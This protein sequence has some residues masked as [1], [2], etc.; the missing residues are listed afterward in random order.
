MFLYLLVVMGLG[1]VVLH[2]GSKLKNPSNNGNPFKT[3]HHLS[4]KNQ[5]QTIGENRK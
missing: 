4:V 3:A 2:N 5:N 1:A